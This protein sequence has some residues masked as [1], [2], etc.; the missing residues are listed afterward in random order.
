MVPGI[1][2]LD[3]AFSKLAEKFLYVFQFQIAA[4]DREA[5]IYQ[6]YIAKLDGNNASN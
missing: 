6:G 3:F 1:F 4:K 2:Y 5:L